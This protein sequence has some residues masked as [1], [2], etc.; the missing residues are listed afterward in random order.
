[1]ESYGKNYLP[2]L[3]FQFL[4]RFY[5][6]VVRMTTREFTFK[7]ALL[8]QA[9][10]KNGQTILDLACG[11]G[12]L[13]VA[14][15]KNFP[16]TLVTGFDADREI[17]R[18]AREKAANHS[19]D[20]QFRRGFSDALPFPENN[21]DRVF[22]TLAFHHLT[23][24]KKIETL[25]E[26]RRVLKPG[27]EF[28]LAD[29]GLPRNKRQFILSKVVRAIDGPDTTEDNLRG[30]LGLLMEQN[31]FPEVERTGYFKTVIG[32]IRLFRAIK[33]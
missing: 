5:D 31:G 1:M 27:G 18:M 9:R 19:T 25:H 13:S 28:H 26:I 17:L 20:I 10:L 21:F 22:S 8:K 11:T 4:T 12:T 6:P 33:P 2:A 23:L 14:I 15:K 3:R 30:R 32:T 16:E 29:Y 24:D 7:R